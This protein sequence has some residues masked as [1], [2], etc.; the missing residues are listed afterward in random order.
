MS[1]GGSLVRLSPEG[2]GEFVGFVWESARSFDTFEN[3]VSPSVSGV[4]ELVIVSGTGPYA[5][6]ASVVSIDLYDGASWVTVWSASLGAEAYYSLGGLSVRFA[7]QSVSGVRV[8]SAPGLSPTF[9]GWEDVVFHFGRR[10]SG[11][12]SVA[13]EWRIEASAAEEVSVSSMDVVVNAGGQVDVSAVEGVSV[14]ASDVSVASSGLTEVSSRDV[15]VV[16]GE[17][18]EAYGGEEV[19]VT[20]GAIGVE[21]L[22]R[23]DAVAVAGVSLTTED[24]TVRADGAAEAYVRSATVGVS[25]SL[26][27]HAGSSLGLSTGVLSLSVEGGVAAM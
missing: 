7:S 24:V 22:G 5:R 15:S 11:S 17:R 12:V 9:E 10:S 18:L 21:S 2:E 14:S 23:L 13:S 8:R 27:V 6:G 3:T 25:S 26:D 1:S 4:E 16:A 20:G 19:R